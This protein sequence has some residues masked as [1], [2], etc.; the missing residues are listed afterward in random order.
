MASTVK[1]RLLY[2]SGDNEEAE[3]VLAKSLAVNPDDP[4]LLLPNI[5][6]RDY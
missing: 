5:S 6:D 1:S 4:T 3:A 2:R